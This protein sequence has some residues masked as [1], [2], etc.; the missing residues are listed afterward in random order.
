M[1]ISLENIVEK[2]GTKSLG[3]LRRAYSYFTNPVIS[4]GLYGL[5][6][7]L[8]GGL[9]KSRITQIYGLPGVGKSYLSLFIAA[10]V[11]RTGGIVAFLDAESSLSIYYAKTSGIDFESLLISSPESAEEALD[12]IKILV[13]H[14]VDL[15]IVDS[16][17]GLTTEKELNNSMSK[18]TTGSLPLLLEKKLPSLYPIGTKAYQS[19][20]TILFINQLRDGK[21]GKYIP[22]G[23]PLISHSSVLIFLSRKKNIVDGWRQ[24][25]F[26]VDFN[27]VKNKVFP[28]DGKYTTS[29]FYDTGYSLEDDILN[30]NILLGNVTI[31]GT[32]YYYNTLLLAQGRIAAI[33]RLKND[34]NLYIELCNNIEGES[35]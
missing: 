18:N 19:S 8:G 30:T 11:Q 13:K 32:W 35:I 25:G 27:V 28:S 22:G 14:N 6:H 16:V 23:Q 2:L 24:V 17:A 5:D 15:I 20:S 12:I 10:A 4:T 33:Y 21:D 1:E 29:I 3:K 34:H 31:R 26:E 7:I 9:P